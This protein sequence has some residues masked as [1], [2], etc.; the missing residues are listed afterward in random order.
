MVVFC[1]PFSLQSADVVFCDAF[2]PPRSP[3]LHC[4]SLVHPVALFHNAESVAAASSCQCQWR[5]LIPHPSFHLPH[6][7]V[8]EMA[9]C[10]QMASKHKMLK[11]HKKAQTPE[12]GCAV[13]WPAASCHAQRSPTSAPAPLLSPR[14]QPRPTSTEP[15]PPGPHPPE[16]HPHAGPPLLSPLHP[17]V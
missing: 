17:V 16:P 13:E 3:N 7:A 14:R 8:R 10:N 1:I 12:P 2:F 5:H 11:S 6:P 4:F 15:C 9:R